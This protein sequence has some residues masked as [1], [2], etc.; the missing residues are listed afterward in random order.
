MDLD[1]AMLGSCECRMKGYSDKF[2]GS[3]LRFIIPFTLV[4]VFS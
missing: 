3:V 2:T 4:P 1:P